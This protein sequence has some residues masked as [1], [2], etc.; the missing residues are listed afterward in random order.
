V[1]IMSEIV[2]TLVSGG[3]GALV[4]TVVSLV[5]S[6]RFQRR[7]VRIGEVR[8]ELEQAYGP[9]YSMVSQPETIMTIDSNEERRVPITSTQKNELDRIMTTLPHMFPNKLLVYWQ[10]NISALAPSITKDKTERYGIPTEFKLKV[11]EQYK[12]RLDEYYD[13]MG[14]EKEVPDWYWKL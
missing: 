12:K 8:H 9:I 7:M 10:M 11:N 2:L 5:F 3:I 6:N 14:R 1:S 13:L 4:A